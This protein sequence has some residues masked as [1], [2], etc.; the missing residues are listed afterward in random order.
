MV[1]TGRLE[2]PTRSSEDRIISVSL[3]AQIFGQ[4]AETPTQNYSLG[5]NCDMHFHHRLM[6]KLQGVQP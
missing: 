3:R 5:E 6:E 4:P 1:S 2:L